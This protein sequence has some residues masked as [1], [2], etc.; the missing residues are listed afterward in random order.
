MTRGVMKVACVIIRRHMLL[1]AL[2]LLFVPWTAHAG[3]LGAQLVDRRGT[4][5]EPS[6]VLVTG[7]TPGGPAAKATIQPKD[8]IVAIGDGPVASAASLADT[9]RRTTPGSS[10]VL[11]IIREGRLVPIT[12]S[13]GDSPEDMADYQRGRE[14][15][16][17]GQNEQAII[18]FTKALTRSP[19]IADFYF[20]RARAYERLG[21]SDLAVADYTKVVELNPRSFTSYLNRGYVYEKMRRHDQAI[22][23]FTKAIEME[24]K[25]APIYVDRG[26]S[27]FSKGLHDQAIADCT[28]AIE[29]QP[30]MDIAYLGRAAAYNAK[31]MKREALADRER[32]AAAYVE[33]GLEIAKKGELDAALRKFDSAIKLNTKHSSSAYCNRGVV[34]EKRKDYLRAVNDYT[35]A[36]RLNPR[37]AEAYVRRGYV[38]AHGLGDYRNAQKDWEKAQELDPSG[39]M[40]RSAKDSLERLKSAQSKP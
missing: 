26:R 15:L 12:V 31:G 28:R 4:D 14:N 35:E 10:L 27:Y 7:V 21:K 25:M 23:D 19:G 6:G 8:L 30:K 13:L 34:N 17:K 36:I 5:A 9:V 32:A 37:C 33:S 39:E 16:E 3:Y 22:K 40:G 38:F 11:K 2:S 20:Y 1:A 18:D 24:P 29:L